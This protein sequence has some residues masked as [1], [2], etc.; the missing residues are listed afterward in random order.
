MVNGQCISELYLICYLISVL[1]TTSIIQYGCQPTFLICL[2][3]LR[4]YDLLLKPASL[5]LD[6]RLENSMVF[7]VTRLPKKQLRLKVI[8][9]QRVKSLHSSYKTL[10][11]VFQW[12]DGR[13]GWFCQTL[14]NW[15]EETKPTAE[16][17]YEQLSALVDHLNQTMLTSLTLR[18]ITHNGFISWH[19]IT[20]IYWSWFNIYM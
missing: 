12:G 19:C 6:K 9:W 17:R 11:S 10:F 7:G 16:K 15:H 3:I 1:R 2:S 5:P 14:K 18:S 13:K 8:G 20:R 4:R